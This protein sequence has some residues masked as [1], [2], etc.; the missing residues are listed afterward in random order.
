MR[1]IEPADVRWFIGMIVMSGLLFVMAAW[2]S[3]GGGILTKKG[4][5]LYRHIF[6]DQ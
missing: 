3:I 1:K 2:L 5:Q 4:R 6:W